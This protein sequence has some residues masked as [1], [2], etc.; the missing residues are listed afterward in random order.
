MHNNN[1]ENLDEK[2]RLSTYLNIFALYSY[3]WI[4]SILLSC[5]V[6]VGVFVGLLSYHDC[7]KLFRQ[8]NYLEGNDKKKV[9]LQRTISH[10][11]IN[12]LWKFI[13]HK[14]IIH[15]QRK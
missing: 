1:N 11:I 4:N 2:C 6:V 13:Q 7:N 9:N 14:N 15:G 5:V 3:L 10:R 8:L 12:L